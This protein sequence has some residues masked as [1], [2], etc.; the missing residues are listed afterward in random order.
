MAKL[1]TEAKVGLFVLVA[2]FLFAA[3]SVQVGGFRWLGDRG[4]EVSVV[5]PSASG[6]DQK[7]VVEIAGIK[8]GEVKAVGLEDSRARIVMRIQKG[9]RIPVDSRVTI[10]TRGLLGAKFIEIIPGRVD[11]TEP[12]PNGPPISRSG[13]F[14]PAEAAAL[15]RARSPEPGRDERFIAPGGEIRRTVPTADTD[16]LVQQ[17]SVIADDVKAVTASLRAALGTREGERQLKE[18]VANISQLSANLSRLVAQNDQK[19]ASL[20][21][22]LQ[23]FSRDLREVSSANKADVKA[24][25]ANLRD[26][27]EALAD[28]SPEILANLQSLSSSLNELVKE[29]RQNINQG[30]ENVK[31][32]AARLDKT[33]ESVASVAQKID[34]GQGT[35]G[36]LVNDEEIADNLSSAVSGIGELFGT[37]Q[38]L[39]TTFGFRSEYQFRGGNSKSAV[40]LELAPGPDRSY[41]LEVVSNPFGRRRTSSQTTTVL[42]ASGN[43]VSSTS[44]RSVGQKENELQVT[45]LVQKWWDNFSLRGGLI[46]SS[47]GFGVGYGLFGRKVE[48]RADAFNFLRE[49][50]PNIRAEARYRFFS[51]LY[52]V[53]GAENL[54]DDK[55]ISGPRRTLFLGAGFTFEDR[56]LAALV[57]Q[58]PTGAVR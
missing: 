15:G 2:L 47:G 8:V 5:V 44:S 19:I 4:Y 54:L 45:F 56:D 38:R 30:L 53:A 13:G 41:L 23:A 31:N 34:E 18:I 12:A 58:A 7:T 49:G 50:G 25:L 37:A 10:K 3:F 43:V 55:D 6:I 40:S 24:T 1:S 17:L 51:T 42:D 26:F 27:S 21:D 52:A 14:G 29:N 33:L 39:R 36:R 16:Q 20:I 48:L 11:R 57:R 28:N 22:N 46:E 35:L 32:A 9:I